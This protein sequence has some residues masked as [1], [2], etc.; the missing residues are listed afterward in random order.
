MGSSKSELSYIQSSLL[1]EPPLR[2]D[3]R[4]LK[5]YRTIS[6]DTGVVPLANG[7]ARVSLGS[8]IGTNL[9]GSGEPTTRV[10][11]AVKLEVQDVDMKEVEDD[12]GRLVCTV[13]WLVSSSSLTYLQ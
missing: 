3:G 9:P 1:A 8:S 5:D 12:G 11:A 6:L 10:L 4:G 2:G 13:S 7:S